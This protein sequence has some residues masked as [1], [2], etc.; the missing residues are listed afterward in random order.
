MDNIFDACNYIVTVDIDGTSQIN[1]ALIR[2]PTFTS[3]YIQADIKVLQQLLI[4]KF[5]PTKLSK[6]DSVN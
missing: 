2:A 6:L 5:V 1:Y 4:V 3:S